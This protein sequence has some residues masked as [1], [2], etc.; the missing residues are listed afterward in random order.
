MGVGAGRH[1][2]GHGL[3]TPE[4]LRQSDVGERLVSLMLR[5]EGGCGV[6]LLQ[7]KTPGLSR[8]LPALGLLFWVS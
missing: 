1:Q 3:G 5:I 7:T 2:D 6:G 4:C 8:L